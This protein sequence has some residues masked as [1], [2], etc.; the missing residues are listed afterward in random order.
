M[1]KIYI[2]PALAILWLSIAGCKKMLV[3]TPESQITEQVYFHSE[4][5]FDPFVNGTYNLIRDIT[6]A[7]AA[8]QYGTE[9][10]EELINGINSRLNTAAWQQTLSPVNGG[11]NYNNYYKAI[12]NCNLLLERIEPFAFNNAALK[13]RL[14]AETLAQRAFLYFQLVRI[15]GDTPLMLQAITDE[16]VPLLPRSKAADVLKQVFAD[17]DMASALY[18]DKGFSSKYRFSYPAVQA[19]KAE[20]KLWSA[21][22]VGGG[23]ADFNAAIAAVQEVEKSNA[24][25]LSNFRAITTT[26]ANSEVILSVYYHRDEK[27]PNYGI[28]TLPFLAGG[29]EGASNLD[30]I[31]YAKT[32]VNGQGGYQISQKSKD[33]FAGLAAT[34]K[35]IPNT[36][37]IERRGTVQRYSWIN[38]YPGNVYSDDRISDND[39][40]LYRLADIYLIAAEAYA[41]LG[42]TSPAIAYLNKVRVRAGNGDYTGATDKASVELE[43]FKE[44]GREL[45]F[46]NKRWYDIVRFHKGGTIDAYTYVPNLAG[47]TTPLFWPLSTAVLA[48]NTNLIQTDGY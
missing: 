17:I 9:R 32:S 42:T 24:A 5:D 4:S 26:R 13:D 25:L 48:A 43:I 28:N 19:L 30:S 14:K 6:G 38:K 33:L 8:L 31:P 46:E 2:L 22:V 15:I 36:F 12:G 20:A 44:R 40:I 21:K 35:R 27:S 16:N 39:V 23:Q 47:K 45:F 1:K 37:I 29:V 7:T 18:A 41:G 10:S 34:D 11:F 3:V